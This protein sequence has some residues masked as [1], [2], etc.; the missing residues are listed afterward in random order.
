[1]KKLLCLF[2]PVL[3]IISLI[4]GCSEKTAF[5]VLEIGGYDCYS[6]ANHKSEVIL[7]QERII[8]QGISRNRKIVCNGVEYDLSYE[9]TCIGYLYNGTRDC[10]TRDDGRSTIKIELN[11]QTGRIDRYYFDDSDYL[12]GVSTPSLSREECLLIAQQYLSTYIDDCDRYELVFENYWNIEEYGG[13]YDF[14]FSRIV[15]GVE[16]YDMASIG[17]TIY[18]TVMSHHFLGLET[19]RDAKLPTSEEMKAIQAS[20]ESRLAEIYDPIKD[21]YSVSYDLVEVIFMRLKDGSYALQYEY[22]A[23][24]TSNSDEQNTRH[25]T[26]MLLVRLN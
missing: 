15:D 18:G 7:K 21:E 12:E 10:Y 6:Q 9:E 8:E 11:R 13:L 23:E 24:L 16:T 3:M 17:V 5:E 1:M 20:V 22:C 4:T 2:I 14:Q 25:D 26:T 19:M